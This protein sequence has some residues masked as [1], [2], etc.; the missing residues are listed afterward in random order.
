VKLLIISVVFLDGNK[1]HRMKS[2]AVKAISEWQKMK[3]TQYELL[4]TKR[5]ATKIL[6]NGNRYQMQMISTTLQD[7]SPHCISLLNIGK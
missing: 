7:N 4:Q 2:V 1:Y 5:N 3:E 6:Q